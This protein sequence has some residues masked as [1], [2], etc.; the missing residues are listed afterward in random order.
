MRGEHTL[1]ND[2]VYDGEWRAGRKHGRGTYYYALR[3]EW[4]APRPGCV[5]GATF[6]GE[7]A[8]GEREGAGT[9]WHTDGSADFCFYAAGSAT[10]EGARWSSDRQTAWRLLDGKKQAEIS[11]DEARALAAQIGLPEEPPSPPAAPS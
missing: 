1:A 5:D 6:E 10:G 8:N 7:F 3:V 4:P 9:Y 11:L 2:D